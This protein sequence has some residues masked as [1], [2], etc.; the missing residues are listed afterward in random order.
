MAGAPPRSGS[1][2]ERRAGVCHE[3]IRAARCS[4]RCRSRTTH[5]DLAL[6]RL[7][8]LHELP[9]RSHRQRRSDHR[10]LAARLTTQ[11]ARNRRSGHTA[12]SDRVPV[13][14]RASR[15]SS[16]APCCRRVAIRHVVPPQGSARA[17]LALDQHRLTQRLL[18]PIS[19]EP[20]DH[21]D[22]RAGRKRIDDADRLIGIVGSARAKGIAGSA[23]RRNRAS[24]TGNG[25]IQ[26]RGRK[27][28][29]RRHD[30]IARATEKPTASRL[31]RCRPCA[32][33]QSRWL[34]APD[35]PERC[36]RSR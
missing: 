1:L 23:A 24:G 31:L 8:V 2:R 36:R 16:P 10:R 12:G 34:T 6:V 17:A 3:R 13:R 35:R 25:W 9:Q 21:I 27:T 28:E 15:A 4:A 18:Q 11:S 19:D 26:C 5:R 30:V 14:L 22:Q 33:L 7:G 32:P 20:T 29:K